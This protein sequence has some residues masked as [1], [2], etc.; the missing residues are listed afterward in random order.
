MTQPK[1]ELP[2]PVE[3]IIVSFIACL[4]QPQNS[5]LVIARHLSLCN[6]CFVLDNL[7]LKI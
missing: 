2:V 3:C 4:H 6:V 1:G 5:Q 7:E